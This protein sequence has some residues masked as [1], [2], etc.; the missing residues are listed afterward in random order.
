MSRGVKPMVRGRKGLYLGEKTEPLKIPLRF[1][2]R[3]K[4]A[5]L[6]AQVS[7]LRD[8]IAAVRQELKEWNAAQSAT[9]LVAKVDSTAKP[10]ATRRPRATSTGSGFGTSAS[11]PKKARSGKAS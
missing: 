9:A 5:V 2:D 11:A 1:H 7:E 10:K 8:E 6:A 4:H 3:V